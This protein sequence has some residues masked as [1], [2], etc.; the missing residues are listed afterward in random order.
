MD[1]DYKSYSKEELEDAKRNVDVNAYP[2]RYAAINAEIA[3]RGHRPATK[4]TKAKGQS[5]TFSRDD[6]NN[7]ESTDAQPS[8]L[9]LHS[10]RKLTPKKKLSLL[11]N[12]LLLGGFVYLTQQLRPSLDKTHKY[13]TEIHGSYCEYIEEDEYYHSHNELI[14][15]VY[16]DTFWL[17]YL[18][19]DACFNTLKY[20]RKAR[21]ISL[22]HQ[23]GRIY[24]L[25]ADG[26]MLLT[27]EEINEHK[28]MK[29]IPD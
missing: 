23:D 29:A 8:V 9:T 1:V 7:L 22:W 13:T 26:H 18:N 16:N 17:P 27:F 24:Q 15:T 19:T 21:K 25:A 14:L 11:L 2:E 3:R 20:V 12:T 28:R 6:H 5:S 4:H 10:A